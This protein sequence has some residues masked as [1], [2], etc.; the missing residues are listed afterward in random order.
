M[1]GK[2]IK[3]AGGG[4]KEAKHEVKGV[5]SRSM[6]TLTP[7]HIGLRGL[8][9]RGSSTGLDHQETR[10]DHR[11]TSLVDATSIGGKSIVQN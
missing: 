10:T 8:G 7:C 9:K 4:F 6:E 1:A 2:E 11:A 5:E 3:I